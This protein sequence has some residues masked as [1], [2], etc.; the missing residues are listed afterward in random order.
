MIYNTRDGGYLGK[1]IRNSNIG[2]RGVNKAK[3]NENVVKLIEEDL[4]FLKTSVVNED[5]VDI[6]KLKLKETAKSR[7]HMMLSPKMDLIEHFP[8]F[9]T[10]PELVSKI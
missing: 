9:Y 6:I 7:L 4:L 5:T 3:E 2:N 10:H 8:F 1:R